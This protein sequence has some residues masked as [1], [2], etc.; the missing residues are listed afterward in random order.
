VGDIGPPL[1]RATNAFSLPIALRLTDGVTTVTITDGGAD[2]MNPAPDVI[3]FLGALGS[4]N[5]N[6]SSGF[7]SST[8]GSGNLDLFSASVATGG[9]AS[10]LSVL[11]AQTDNTLRVP[12]YA[13]ELGGTCTNIASIAYSA[14][15]DDA[16][17]AFALSQLIG[18][19]GP[20]TTSPRAGP[21]PDRLAYP[22]RIRSHRC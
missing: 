6:V 10:A 16:N 5:I 20:F 15:A 3:T 7:G 8:V 13:M 2:D 18:T 14:Y 4:W 12:A 22:L 19:V 11:F 21:R 17:D 9:T 1:F